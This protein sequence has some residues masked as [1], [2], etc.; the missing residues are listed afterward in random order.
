[1]K[2]LSQFVQ[3]CSLVFRGGNEYLKKIRCSFVPFLA[4]M[5]ANAADMS[6][7]GLSSFFQEK[8]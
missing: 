7:Y 3:V 1:M 2:K 4:M 6:T 5:E 8:T